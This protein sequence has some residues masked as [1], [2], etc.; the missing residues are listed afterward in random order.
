MRKATVVLVY[1]QPRPAS[2]DP[3]VPIFERK[4]MRFDDGGDVTPE[5][6]NRFLSEGSVRCGT[7]LFERQAVETYN[8]RWAAQQPKRHLYLPLD[9]QTEARCH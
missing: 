9:E 6:M 8:V 1:T 3:A 4:E 5:D 7:T 2:Y